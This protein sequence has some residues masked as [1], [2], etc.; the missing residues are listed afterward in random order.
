MVGAAGGE[1]SFTDME[2]KVWLT[3][4]GFLFAPFVCVTLFCLMMTHCGRGSWITPW[5]RCCA[6]C[7]CPTLVLAETRSDLHDLFLTAPTMGEGE[8]MVRFRDRSVVLG[9]PL[10][11]GPD[12]RFR[13]PGDRLHARGQQALPQA[14]HGPAVRV[15]AA[16]GVQLHRQLP[17]SCSR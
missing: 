7:P 9:V 12:L 3:R 17:A 11:P 6:W 8:S 16:G 14:V 5:F 1:R 2:S 4:L 15:R 10:R 13:G